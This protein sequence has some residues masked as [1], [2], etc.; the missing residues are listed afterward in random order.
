MLSP[1]TRRNFARVIPF[2]VLWFIFALVYCVLE[3]GILGHLSHYPSTG[4]P[5]N[6]GRSI[7]VIPAAG[8][9]MG[10]F[11]GFLE[12]G[13]FSRWFIKKSFTRKI[14][15]KSFIY[16]VIVI[17]F[18]III[19]LINALYTQEKYTFKNLSSSPLA[20][21]TDYAMIGIMLYFA[22]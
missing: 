1:K 15:F 8:M 13:Y 10:I 11:T 20:F 12:I 4:V 21:L 3:R 14:V 17:T 5:Y 18:L 9:F 19:T 6:F 7:V 22:V 2:G 16:L